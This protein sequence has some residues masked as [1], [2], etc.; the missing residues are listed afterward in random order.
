MRSHRLLLTG[1]LGVVTS[2]AIVSV[3]VAG[4]AAAEHY[5]AAAFNMN[6]SAVGHIDITVTQWSTDAQR[7]ALLATLEAKGPDRLLDA[8]HDMPSVGRFG[9]PGQLSWDLR[10]ARRIPNP[11]GGGERIVLVTDRPINFGEAANQTRSLNYPFTV[12]EL[13]ID[14]EGRGEGK[15]STAT[16]IVVDKKNNA[17]TLGE[18]RAPASA[19]HA[20]DA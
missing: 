20:G 12:I 5:T 8:V 9:A 7:D 17:I 16:R 13:R 15:M 6:N 11:D 4:L 1:L 14:D 3:V 2:T 18:L 19:A 10:F